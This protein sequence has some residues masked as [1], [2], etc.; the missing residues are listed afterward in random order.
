MLQRFRAKKY[1]GKLILHP[2]QCPYHLFSFLGFVTFWYILR[3]WTGPKSSCQNS[4]LAVAHVEIT[5]AKKR[6]LIAMAKPACAA[7]TPITSIRL[8]FASVT[9]TT[10]HRFLVRNSAETAKPTATKT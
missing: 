3:S 5:Y 2:E 4:A 6:N 9:L 7:T 10:G 1:H 8:I